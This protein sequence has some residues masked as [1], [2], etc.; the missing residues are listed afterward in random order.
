MRRA[1]LAVLFCLAGLAPARA[2]VIIEQ[3]PGGEA[4]SFIRFFEA[5]RASGE[6]VVID[7]PC[8]S[9]CTL[10]LGL[11]PKSR[12]CVTSRAILG[13]HAAKLVDMLGNRYA[14]PEETRIVD[15]T[16]PARVRV[17]IHRH[18]GLTD[19]PIFLFGTELARMY[20]RCG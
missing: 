14:A 20:G 1:L 9:A 17:W 16:Y 7:G 6:R 5:V 3:S 10:A 2:D 8:F 15:E 19:R 13:F 12:I 4:S 18:G 11:I